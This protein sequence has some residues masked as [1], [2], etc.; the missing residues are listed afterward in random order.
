MYGRFPF[1][2][3]RRAMQV[4]KGKDNDSFLVFNIPYYTSYDGH[5]FLGMRIE[6][7]HFVIDS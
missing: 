1:Q 6:A 5:A 2:T 3:F 4:Q 7:S